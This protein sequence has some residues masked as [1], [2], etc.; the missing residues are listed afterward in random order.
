MTRIIVLV[1]VSTSYTPYIDEDAFTSGLTFTQLMQLTNSIKVPPLEGTQEADHVAIPQIVTA[2]PNYL[3]LYH[4][5]AV[6][7]LA[8]DCELY[9]VPITHEMPPLPALMGPTNQFD[10]AMSNF[11]HFINEPYRFETLLLNPITEPTPMTPAETFDLFLQHEERELTEAKKAH[12]R[13]L[14]THF[15]FYPQYLGL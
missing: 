8:P 3:V 12:K 14:C 1:G 6:Y 9:E 13:A 7:D 10:T 2:I 11:P 5:V 15:T 4:P